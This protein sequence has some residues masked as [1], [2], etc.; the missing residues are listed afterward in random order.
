MLRPSAVD[1]LSKHRVFSIHLTQ[2]K[3]V[4]AEHRSKLV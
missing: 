2:T 4:K 1:I 3:I